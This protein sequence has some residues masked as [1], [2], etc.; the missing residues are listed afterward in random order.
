MNN[1]YSYKDVAMNNQIKELAVN[2]WD[3]ELALV[4]N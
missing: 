3:K 1:Q 2:R 4:G